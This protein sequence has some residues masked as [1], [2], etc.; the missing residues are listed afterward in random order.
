MPR[1]QRKSKTAQGE[2]AALV[3]THAALAAAVGCERSTITKRLKHAD[4]P[5]TS[6]GPWD[7]DDVATL[8]EWMTPDDTAGESDEL[9]QAQAIKAKTLACKY[10]LEMATM[11]A[12]SRTAELD[13]I[14]KALS[15]TSTLHYRDTRWKLADFLV[16]HGIAPE[17]ADPAADDFARTFYNAFVGTFN[18]IFEMHAAAMEDS[19]RGMIRRLRQLTREIEILPDV[20]P[21]IIADIDAKLSEAEGE[22]VK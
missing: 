9:K 15:T 21:A 3:T 1:L 16:A 6:T 11:T 12:G 10:L 13:A 8:A 14:M 17:K 5:V 20:D 4:C 22:V 7:A 18:S 2:R 19:G